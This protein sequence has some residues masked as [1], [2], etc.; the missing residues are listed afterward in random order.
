[1]YLLY[2][3]EPGIHYNIVFSI[4]FTEISPNSFLK[5]AANLALLEL[6]QRQSSLRSIFASEDKNNDPLKGYQMIKKIDK[7]LY[8][9]NWIKASKEEIKNAIE[10]ERNYKFKIEENSFRLNTFEVENDGANLLRTF[11]LIVSQHHIVTDGWSMTIFAEEFSNLYQTFAERKQ[12]LESPATKIQYI[13][14]A[15]YSRENFN[16]NEIISWA[17]YL[18]NFIPSTLTND[19]IPSIKGR[20][21]ES[22]TLHFIIPMDTVEALKHQCQIY[23]T[24]FYTLLLLGFSRTISKWTEYQQCQSLMFGLASSGRIIPESKNII[25]YF[26]NNLIFTIENQEQLFSDNFSD[27]L[28]I[29]KTNFAETKSKENLPYHRLLSEWRKFHQHLLP[30]SSFGGDNIFD[31]YFNYRHNLDFPTVNIPNVE[32]TVTQETNNRIFNL[33]VTIDEIGDKTQRLLIDY[34]KDSYKKETIESFAEDFLKELKIVGNGN[35]SCNSLKTEKCFQKFQKSSKK[36]TVIELIL[37]QCDKYASRPAIK[38]STGDTVTYANLKQRILCKAVGI[39][40]AFYS[41]THRSITSEVVIPVLLEYNEQIEWFLAILVSGAAYCPL[42][43]KNPDAYN[44]QLISLIE[45]PNFI[46]CDKSIASFNCFTPDQLLTYS[47]SS[48]TSLPPTKSEQFSNSLMYI[49]FTSGSTGF[50]KGVQI[51]NEQV[52]NFLESAKFQLNINEFSSIAH[53]V[54]TIFDVSVFN[55]FAALTSGACLIQFPSLMS[56]VENTLSNDHLSHLFL[57]SAVFNTLS[58]FDLEKFK[59]LKNLQYLIVGGETPSKSNIETVN[60][61][62]IKIIQ[63]YGPTEATIWAT[64]DFIPKEEEDFINPAI[65]GKEI[66]TTEVI[67]IAAGQ[68]LSK[69]SKAIGEIYLTGNIARGYL[70]SAS[71]SDQS[72]FKWI[73]GLEKKAFATGDLGRRHENGKIEFLGRKTGFLKHN[74]ARI[75]PTMIEKQ[76]IAADST[77]KQCVITVEEEGQRKVL[78]CFYC[79]KS[80]TINS[81]D[82]INLN[83]LKQRLSLK[84]PP[85]NIPDRFIFVQTIPINLSG[86]VDKQ[87]LKGIFSETISK[88]LENGYQKESERAKIL[89]SIW[90]SLLNLNSSTNFIPESNFFLLGGNSINLFILKSQIN[91]KFN[92]TLDIDALYRIPTFGEQEKLIQ[93]HL[94]KLQYSLPLKAQIAEIKVEL[95]ASAN[96]YCIHAIGGT[97]YPFYSLAQIISDNYNIYGIP[98]DLKYEIK[99]L[100]ELAEFYKLQDQFK[101]IPDSETFINA[102]IF[103]SSLLKEHKFNYDSRVGIFSFK[104]SELTDTPLRRAILPTLTKDLVR[105]FIDNGWAEYSEEITTVLTPGDHDSLLKVENLSKISNRLNEAISH[106]LIEFTEF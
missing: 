106:C 51:E 62:K 5:E 29:I 18:S 9:L 71:Q 27:A 20:T 31:I 95:N 21:F 85:T 52:L 30:S 15:I 93:R 65:I 4:K 40:K 70:K 82:K 75:D 45:N 59:H 19:F 60:K 63:I 24:S 8:Q 3:L 78:V 57:T 10:E 25:G 2:H 43:I 11:T 42:D 68:I 67:F 104:A 37:K 83:M 64:I 36:N 49:L 39:Q 103:L 102:S 77:I 97:I 92:I 98:F 100:E 47:S 105:S 73:L 79:L 96:I 23:S 12:Q 6:I 72:S 48:S 54:N 14:F 1:M 86:K 13:D 26:L 53:S 55:I 69:C 41:V 91:S 90:R 33:S 76:I 34:R 58:N 44:E 17:K 81:S 99:S 56:V 32:A 101:T 46:I 66:P 7:N 35:L 94:T 61:S 74:G 22:S 16:P 84:L 88:S 89:A 50:P 28:Q 87:K 80:A 38:L